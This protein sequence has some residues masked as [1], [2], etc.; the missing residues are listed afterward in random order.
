MLVACRLDA[1]CSWVE[2]ERIESV[3]YDL[4]LLNGHPQKAPFL[5]RHFSFEQQETLQVLYA[6][7]LCFLLLSLVQWRATAQSRFHTVQLRSQLLTWTLHLEVCRLGLQVFNMTLYARNGWAF[8]SLNFLS[9]VSWVLSVSTH[10]RCRWCATWAPR[11]SACCS[12]CSAVAGRCASPAPDCSAT[13]C[14]TSG[15]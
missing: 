12:C 13:T 4:T 6:A 8:P 2:S 3:D 9:E 7:L 15:R 10:S 1:N 5:S 14:S 11:C